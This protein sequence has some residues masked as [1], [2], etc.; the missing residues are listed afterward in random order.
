MAGELNMEFIDDLRA[1]M[2]DE[3]GHLLETYL[4]ASSE[5]FHTLRE[6]TFG[7]ADDLARSAHCLKGSCANIGANKLA[8]L[9]SALELKTRGGEIGEVEVGALIDAIE[10]ELAA[11]SLAVAEMRSV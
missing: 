11:V 4:A 9:C 6:S 2:G 7:S 1:I 8:D 3:F 10:D 5:Q